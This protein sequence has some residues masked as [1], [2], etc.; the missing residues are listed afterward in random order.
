[1]N[2][3]DLTPDEIPIIQIQPDEIPIIQK[4]SE[5]LTPDGIPTI[6]KQLKDIEE[7]EKSE[8]V[9][10]T[11]VDNTDPEIK[12]KKDMIKRVKFLGL[13]NMNK[14]PFMNTSNM[15]IVEKK[16]LQKEMNKYNDI[17]HQDIIDEYN[18]IC[19]E[20][21]SDSKTNYTSFMVSH[22]WD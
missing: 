20:M 5:D 16:L 22:Y 13:C 7:S 21:L 10:K 15:S 18:E 6:Q 8:K 19:G 11:M 14:D 17:S 9:F 4:Q 12:Y 3:E 2:T 1:M